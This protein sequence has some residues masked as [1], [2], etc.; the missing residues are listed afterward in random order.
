MPTYA[1]C[2]CCECCEYVCRWSCVNLMSAAPTTSSSHHRH[3]HHHYDTSRQCG[4]ERSRCNS[5]MAYASD[6]SVFGPLTQP[7]VCA[8]TSVK[9]KRLPFLLVIYVT[10]KHDV[11]L[12]IAA[13]TNT[14]DFHEEKNNQQKTQRNA[15]KNKGLLT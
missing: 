6:S 11:K 3:R 14:A 8:F 9:S 13:A 1:C 7:S 5:I 12:Y 15:E 4:Q 2:E 10:F